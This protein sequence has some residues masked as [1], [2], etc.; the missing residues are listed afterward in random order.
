MTTTV[1]TKQ[2]SLATA[3]RDEGSSVSVPRG[4]EASVIADLLVEGMIRRDP[5]AGD[6]EERTDRLYEVTEFGLDIVWGRLD[7]KG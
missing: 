7:S 2:E 4:T 5:A 1:T 3:L 6:D